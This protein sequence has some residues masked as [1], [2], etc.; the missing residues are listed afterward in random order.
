[1]NKS[2]WALLALGMFAA[3]ACKS[4]DAMTSNHN[5]EVTE[6][7]TPVTLKITGMT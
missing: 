7:A 4:D 3:T 5:Y 6:V 1:M 2:A